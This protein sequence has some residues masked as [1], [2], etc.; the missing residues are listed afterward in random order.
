[1]VVFWLSSVLLLEVDANTT[2][3]FFHL[4]SELWEEIGN[5]RASRASDDG[6]AYCGVERHTLYILNDY[7]IKF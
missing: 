2:S 3:F 6:F 4:P 5:A 1:M 7:L